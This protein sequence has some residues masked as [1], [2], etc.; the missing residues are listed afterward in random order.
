VG[1]HTIEKA[2]FV[3]KRME[4]ELRSNFPTWTIEFVKPGSEL[5]TSFA[6]SVWDRGEEVSPRRGRRYPVVGNSA[7]VS[8]AYDR[9]CGTQVKSRLRFDQPF[10]NSTIR[11]RLETQF[12]SL[13]LL[14]LART[15]WSQSA[16]PAVSHMGFPPT[17]TATVDV[18]I[19]GGGPAGASLGVFLSRYG[20]L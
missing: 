14:F 16:L 12:I 4:E 3:K 10:A 5:N 6:H 17:M 18:L 11:P 15:H 13:S 8:H 7:F 1:M 2:H 19:V 9:E 20:I